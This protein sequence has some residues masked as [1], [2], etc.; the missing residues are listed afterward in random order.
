MA[1]PV[2]IEVPIEQVAAVRFCPCGRPKQ[3]RGPK[4]RT[5]QA[6]VGPVAVRRRDLSCRCGAPGSYAV[7]DVLGVDGSLSHVLRKHVCRLAADASFAAT[8]DLPRRALGSADVG[9]DGP[10]DRPLSA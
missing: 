3:N 1:R 10:R 7:D 9:R 2:T 8:A 4:T 6:S 5:R